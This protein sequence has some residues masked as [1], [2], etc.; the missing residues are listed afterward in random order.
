MP[1]S[2]FD[3]SSFRLYFAWRYSYYHDLLV[4]GLST[5]QTSMKHGSEERQALRVR[6]GNS[7]PQHM[8]EQYWSDHDHIAVDT[9]HIV[10]CVTWYGA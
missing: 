9:V 5:S 8:K 4:K 6:G 1:A 7:S 3:L 2:G 10:A